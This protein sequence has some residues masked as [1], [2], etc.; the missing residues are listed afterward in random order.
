MLLLGLI[1]AL[2]LITALACAA[3][4]RADGFKGWRFGMTP[5]EVQKVKACSPYTTV[6]VTG[7]LECSNFTFLGAKRNISFVFQQDKLVK[8]Q[9]WIYKGKADGEAADA[10]GKLA[11]YLSKTHGKLECPELPDLASLPRRKLLKYLSHL[12]TKAAPTAKLQL[13]PAKDP[14]AFFTFSSLIYNQA[15]GY[16]LFTY[17]QP[18][19]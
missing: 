6:K 9:I 13:K 11:R 3:P 4:A 2:G 1:A 7:G 19:R 16:F 15:H 12:K 14:R 10:L 5:Q 17:L 18:P 8:I